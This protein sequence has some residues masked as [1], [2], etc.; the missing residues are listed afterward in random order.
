MGVAKPVVISSRG[1]KRNADQ[2]GGGGSS[3]AWRDF[4]SLDITN[5]SLWE[6]RHGLG[7]TA[8]SATVSLDGDVLVWNCPTSPT[9]STEI[10][11]GT[12][13]GTFLIF[14]QHLNPWTECGLS[15]PSGVS[16]NEFYPDVFN[17]TVEV[18]TDTIPING[19]LGSLT[20][21]QYG[22]HMQIGAG[23]VSYS[24]DQSGSPALPDA[25]SGF[26]MARMFKNLGTNPDNSEDG[27]N[28]YKSGY[29]TGNA[30]GT[31][32]GARWKCQPTGGDTRH[33]SLI[34]QASFGPVGLN[35][36]NRLLV[37]GGSYSK[38]NPR[39]RALQSGT[40]QTGTATA[41]SGAD[42]KFIHIAISFGAQNNTGGNG[43]SCR[44]KSVR[45]LLQP[46]QNREELTGA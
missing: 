31:V 22:R 2:G 25:S 30:T 5:L 40:G 3:N 23:V 44:I 32:T 33:D 24:S 6:V 35:S 12:A 20:G 38:T 8:K 15:L 16:A 28:L 45:Y 37:Q 13:R 29:L 17:L 7:S 39:V 36:A 27:T 9:S 21:N 14:K 4:T 11:P 42:N 43:G 1:E 34:F 10:K 26:A 19:P 41:F 46:L 18:E